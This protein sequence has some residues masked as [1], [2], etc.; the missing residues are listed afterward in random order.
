MVIF[1]ILGCRGDHFYYHHYGMG[2]IEHVFRMKNME[3]KIW[4]VI[5]SNDYSA[6]FPCYS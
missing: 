4:D 3:E 1:D 6:Q 5:V 2:A